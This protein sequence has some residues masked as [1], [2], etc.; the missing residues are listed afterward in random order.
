MLERFKDRKIL[1]RKILSELKTM[2]GLKKTNPMK[3]N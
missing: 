3:I 2:T 1:H